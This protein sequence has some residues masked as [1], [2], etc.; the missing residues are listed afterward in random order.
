MSPHGVGPYAKGP[1]EPS[2]YGQGP[3]GQGPYG[4]GPYGQGPYGQ[5]PRGQGPYVQGPYAQGPSQV[6]F[7]Q[8]LGCEPY[9]A[10]TGP[11]RL[12]SPGVVT[13]PGFPIPGGQGAGGFGSGIQTG[14]VQTAGGFW[15]RV[16]FPPVCG[17]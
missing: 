17:W 6:P 13:R 4:Q 14:L 15:L 7:D 11:A 8:S 9:V 2:T 12:S 5:G 3:Y 10:N 16:P 1:G